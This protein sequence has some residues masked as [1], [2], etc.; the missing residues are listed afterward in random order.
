VDPISKCVLH[1]FIHPSPI[2]GQINHNVR[3]FLYLLHLVLYLPRHFKTDNILKRNFLFTL[4]VELTG[5][6]I[7]QTK[8]FISLIYQSEELVLS[9]KLGAPS[10]R[11]K[12]L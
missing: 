4:I 6:I 2:I 10:L 9:S 3:F 12:N 8:M 11:I 7:H 5:S 1:R